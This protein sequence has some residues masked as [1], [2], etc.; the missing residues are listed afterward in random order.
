MVRALV[1][2]A[3]FAPDGRH[4]AMSAGQDL[5]GTVALWDATDGAPRTAA[6]PLG[7]TGWGVVFA[8]DGQSLAVACSD[9]LVR[10]CRPGGGREETVLPGHRP[11]Q[12]WGVAFTPDSRLLVSG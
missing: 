4:L 9:G 11:F 8:A 10:V 7:S 5:E 1:A 12:A 3:A 2:S 6:V